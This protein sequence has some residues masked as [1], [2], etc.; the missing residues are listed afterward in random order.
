[1]GFIEAI[2]YYFGD[3]YVDLLKEWFS[4]SYDHFRV[5]DKS[6]DDDRRLKWLIC[7]KHMEA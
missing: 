7:V 4:L 6:R 3:M 1:M 5:S 2:F